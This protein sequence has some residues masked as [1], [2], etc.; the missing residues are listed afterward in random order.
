MICDAMREADAV[1]GRRLSNAIDDPRE[2]R[3]LTDCV[4]NEI[5]VRGV[6]D[7]KRAACSVDEPPPCMYA[8]ARCRAHRFHGARIWQPALQPVPRVSLPPLP[9]AAQWSKDPALAPAQRIVANLRKRRLY[10]F[11]D[12]LLVPVEW[13][14]RVRARTE[15]WS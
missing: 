6:R 14:Y 10:R 3:T 1:W 2:Y 11:V 15:A 9:V 5:Q 7:T 4:L 12:E 8:R 13:T